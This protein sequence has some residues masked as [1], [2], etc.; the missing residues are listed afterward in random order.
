MA[1][2]GHFGYP[3]FTF[4]RIS[5]NFYFFKYFI[6][7][8]PAPILDNPKFTF[9]R[10]SG[11]F[12]SICNFILF[13]K[14]FT[15][16]LPLAILDVWNSLSIAFLAILDQYGI[17]LTKWPPAPILDVRNSLSIAFLAISDRYTT[18]FFRIFLTK[19]LLLV[20][21]LTFIFDSN[22]GHFRS[23]QIFLVFFGGHFGCPKITFDCIS[24]HFW[25]IGHIGCSK[26]TFDGI[27]GH[28]RS[29]RILIIVLHFWQNGRR[30]PFWMGR[31][32]QL[33]NLSDIFG[34][35]MHVSS[36]KNVV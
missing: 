18:L 29:I 30:R 28:F 17:V 20:I 19:R 15:K 9:D 24:G 13:W 33:S 8:P 35:V 21:L 36:L 26:F 16:W 2:G 25:S 4:D 14:F 22:S 11:H 12:R 7:W 5:G 23:I 6:K 3:K 31:Q 34:W 27:F 32:C 1:S 10:I